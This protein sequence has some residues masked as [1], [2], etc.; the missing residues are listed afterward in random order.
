[1]KLDAVQ[2]EKKNSNGVR[3]RT[4]SSLREGD[5]TTARQRKKLDAA[6]QARSSGSGDKV[7]SPNKLPRRLN[8]IAPPQSRSSPTTRT[9]LAEAK[10][11][12]KPAQQPELNNSSQKP[13][14]PVPPLPSFSNVIKR[15]SSATMP[16]SL[17]P[18][19]ASLEPDPTPGPTDYGLLR[20]RVKPSV[21]PSRTPHHI[22]SK[23]RLGTHAS[24]TPN[25]FLGITNTL[26]R[27]RGVIGST[28]DAKRFL[29][30]YNPSPPSSPSPA[31]P[32]PAKG[33]R[34]SSS[35]YGQETGAAVQRQDKGKERA[36]DDDSEWDDADD[37]RVIRVRGKER[38]LR[39]AREEQHRKEQERG[40]DPETTFMLEENYRDKERI[41]KLEAE[42]AWL[43]SQVRIFT[44][45]LPTAFLLLLHIA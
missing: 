2:H 3:K 33:P 10:H 5:A 27:A 42:V 20:E 21:K 34:K 38:E 4:V 37:S 28:D 36:R 19:S 25:P 43:K 18:R 32:P 31:V 44:S 16:G 30:D 40:M 1:M 45:V 41:R 26:A 15:K 24:A 23:E 6:P 7:H 13:P 9:T 11:T 22:N 29:E 12:D 14:S 35:P 8:A 17:F 39:D